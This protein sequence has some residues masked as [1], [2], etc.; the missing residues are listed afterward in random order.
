MIDRRYLSSI[1]RDVIEKTI[2]DY[3]RDGGLVWLRRAACL[4]NSE[5]VGERFY[6]SDGLLI[7]ETPLN[8]GKKYGIEYHWYETG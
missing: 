3:R 1:P 8:D 4:L 7:T 2:S 6:D 5:I